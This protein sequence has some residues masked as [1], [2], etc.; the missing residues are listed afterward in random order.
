MNLSLSDL[1]H[2][3]EQLLSQ[4]LSSPGPLTICF[5]FLGGFLTSLG[6]CSLSLLP[7]TLAYLAGFN[8]VQKPFIRSL[9][10]CSGIV[11]SLILLG[12]ISGLVGKIYGQVPAIINIS[13][14]LLA[15][16]MGLNL[17][18]FLK[19]P[20]PEGPNPEILK[21]KLPASLAPVG[22]GLTFGLAASPCTTPVIAVLLGWIAKS[23]SVVVGVLLLASFGIGQ[24]IPLLIA[25]TAAATIPKLLSL[26]SI[27]SWIPSISGAI[28]VVTGSLTL[29]AN[30]L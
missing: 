16:A 6:P 15:I 2:Q 28:F 20:L 18:G 27:S 25:G 8:N 12:S 29:L 4:A 7:I 22:V 5:V 24:V 10:F 30:L 17:L 11:L 1:A 3:S 14:G 23:G 9:Q 13:V 26:R 21:D 19:I